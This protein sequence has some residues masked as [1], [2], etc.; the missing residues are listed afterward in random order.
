MAST[1]RALVIELNDKPEYQRVLEGPPQ[2]GGMKV[3]RVVLEPGKACGE[4]T[5]GEREELLVF[6]SGTGELLIGDEKE[7]FEVGRGKV[8]YIKPQTTHDVR[9]TGSESLS[10][11]FCVAPPSA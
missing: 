5:T 4:H 6:L 9:N 8:A 1:Q 3:G 7:V 10:Y 2:T 11:V